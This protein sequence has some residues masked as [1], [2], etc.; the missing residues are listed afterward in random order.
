M[1][2]SVLIPCPVE[3][4]QKDRKAAVSPYLVA[5]GERLIPLFW[6][7]LLPWIIETGLWLPCVVALSYATYTEF[8]AK[9]CR[10]TLC[11]IPAWMA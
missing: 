8:F 2:G 11:V 9:C 4:G 7:L 1:E 5:Q 6:W 3:E 10:V